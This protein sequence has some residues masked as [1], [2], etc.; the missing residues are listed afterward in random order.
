M[1]EKRLSPEEVAGIISTKEVL[2]KI[3]QGSLINVK[4]LC[5]CL[6]ISRKT[7]YEYYHKEREKRGKEEQGFRE[8]SARSQE[9]ERE[10]T[11]LKKRLD[12][13]EIENG[14]LKIAQM[15]VEDLK[16]RGS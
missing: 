2:E 7:A 5:E 1:E 4:S 14:A 3:G 11:A 6:G 15:A 10:L 16:K 13:L 12:W 9:K 8:L